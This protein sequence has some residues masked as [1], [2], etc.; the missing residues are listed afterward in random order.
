MNLKTDMNEEKLLALLSLLD[1]SDPDVYI[2]ISKELSDLPASKIPQLEDIWL[3]SDNPVFQ[4]RLEIIIDEIHHNSVIKDLIS[5][6]N[7]PKQNLIDGAILIN[8]SISYHISSDI[9]KSNI[10]KFV[11]DIKP[12][13]KNQDTY[14]EKIK[15]LNHFLYYI[16]NFMVLSPQ[17]ET[18]WGGNISS[19]LSQKKGNYI[20]TSI[21][22]AAIAQ[23]LKLPVTG[24]QLPNSILLSCESYLTDPETRKTKRNYFYIN[25][26]DR[27]AVLSTAQLEHVIKFKKL[28]NLSQYYKPS[29]NLNLIKLLIQSQIFSYGRQS[30]YKYVEI[31]KELLNV[32]LSKD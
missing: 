4:E 32:L 25:P 28:N 3:E 22:Y 16:H 7:S 15:I 9:V 17:E 20:I 12:E 24:I 10:K 31:L 6:K 21:I 26:I 18:N 30:N 11:D 19:V 8:R 23:D 5:W 29:S 2:N 14:L 27:G 1:D 13:I